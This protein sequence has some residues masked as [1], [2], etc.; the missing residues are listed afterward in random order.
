MANARNHQIS[1][2]RAASHMAQAL[3]GVVSS[4]M[5]SIVLMLM[6]NIASNAIGS[7]AVC[8]QLSGLHA[9]LFV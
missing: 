4:A 9:M 2:R 6:P 8:Y 1:P 3:M 5:A 7:I